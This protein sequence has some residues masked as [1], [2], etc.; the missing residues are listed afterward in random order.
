MVIMSSET[1]FLFDIKMGLR[2]WILC[3]RLPKSK[4][5]DIAHVAVVRKRDERQKLPGHGCK[6]CVEVIQ[7]DPISKNNTLWLGPY[8]ITTT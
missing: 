7:L 6:Q 1:S 2:V 3:Y 4:T 5:S 8:V